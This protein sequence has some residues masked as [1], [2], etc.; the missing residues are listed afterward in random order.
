MCFQNPYPVTDDTESEPETAG[1]H[2]RISRPQGLGV[3]LRNEAV[4]ASNEKY[5]IN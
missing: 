5:G 1:Q 3:Y 2:T 4:L